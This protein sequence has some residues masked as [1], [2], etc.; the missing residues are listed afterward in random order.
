[1]NY[2]WYDAFMH[3]FPKNYKNGNLRL[4]RIQILRLYRARHIKIS[5]KTFWMIFFG[6]YGIYMNKNRYE[7]ELRKK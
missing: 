4:G 2:H 7:E 3:A 6:K 5:W 1:M